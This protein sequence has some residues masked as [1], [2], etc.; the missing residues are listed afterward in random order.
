MTNIVYILHGR[1]SSPESPKCR[2][3]AAAARR[4]GWKVVIP[5]YRDLKSADERLRRFVDEHVDDERPG[6][7][8][9]VGS[10]MGAYVALE[11][12]AAMSADMLLLLAP[13]IYLPGYDVLDPVPHARRTVLVHGW[14]D[15]VVPPSFAVRFADRHKCELH[16]LDDTHD[17]GSSHAFIEELFGSMLDR[18]QP[19]PKLRRLA[20]T[21]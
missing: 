1:D 15:D 16:L 8:I 7:V 13:A 3:L 2:L 19:V 10:S 18:L 17:L 14:C 5:D 9:L 11:A 21:F 20:P 6:K 4:R 12:S